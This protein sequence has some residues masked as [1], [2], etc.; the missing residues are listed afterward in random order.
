[1][2]QG[3]KQKATGRKTGPNDIRHVVWAISAFFLFFSSFFFVT[4]KCL[5]QIQVINYELCDDGRWRRWNPAQTT[6]FGPYPVLFLFFLLIIFFLLTLFR[7]NFLITTNHH[8]HC[9]KIRGETRVG[10]R[11]TTNPR[12]G[13]GPNNATGV[14]WALGEFYCYYFFFSFDIDSWSLNIGV[15]KYKIH[16]GPSICRFFFPKF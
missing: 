11:V 7:S 9:L 2:R 6:L 4:N 15:V 13:E 8:P 14:V 5:L 3:R 12:E 10:R 16:N 1:M